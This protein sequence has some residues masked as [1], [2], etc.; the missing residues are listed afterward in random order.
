MSQEF[1]LHT[2]ANG[3]LH[4]ELE[5]A[6]ANTEVRVTV[7]PAIVEQTHH[8]PSSRANFT[9]ALRNKAGGCSFDVPDDIHQRKSEIFTEILM[10]KHQK[11]IEGQQA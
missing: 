9:E 7:E 4:L 6:W 8:A 3:D 5:T 11:I 1:T 2:N 10:E